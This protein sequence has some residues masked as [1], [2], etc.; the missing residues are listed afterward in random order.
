M[1]LINL[2]NINKVFGKNDTE[3]RALKDF[4]LKIN[5]GEIIAIIG[6]SGSGKSTLLN[7]IGALD[8]QNTGDYLLEGR[9][10]KKLKNREL[11]K[12]RNEYF[13]FVV[14]HFALINDYTVYE[15]IRIPL[16][17]GQAKSSEH[18][19]K[20]K[21]VLTNLDIID[22]INKKPTELS[23]GQCQRVAIARAIVNNPKIILADEPT[24]A[25]DKKTGE[26]VMEIFKE[27][28]KE[29]KTIIIVTHDFNI[30]SKCHRIIE[31][32]DGIIKKEIIN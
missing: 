9:D 20:I 23:G 4:N 10:L 29:G 2:N 12:I 7:I 18:E 31:L 27:L 14:Q 3:I 21:D 8:K 17:Y 1:E 15:N 28:N 6:A 22:K 19:S 30:A 16:D 5:E 32:E 13:G 25:L 11:A 24:G 26:Q